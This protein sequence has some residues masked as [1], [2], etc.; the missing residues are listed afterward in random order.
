MLKLK[1]SH[2][3]DFIAACWNIEYAIRYILIQDRNYHVDW[4]FPWLYV[5]YPCKP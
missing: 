2:V 5:S 1:V 3:L 4:T